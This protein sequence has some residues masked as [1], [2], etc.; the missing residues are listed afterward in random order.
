MFI[1]KELVESFLD[2]TSKTFG[3]EV[4]RRDKEQSRKSGELARFMLSDTP[5]FVRNAATGNQIEIVCS[6]KD[7]LEEL[8]RN[9]YMEMKVLSE[10]TD[11]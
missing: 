10:K 11:E 8:E 2:I 7:K 6:N 1:A 9:F 4:K 3:C 5:V